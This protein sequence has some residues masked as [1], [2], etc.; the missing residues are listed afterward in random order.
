MTEPDRSAARIGNLK[1][2]GAGAPGFVSGCSAN[3]R[4][5]DPVTQVYPNREEEAGSRLGRGQKSFSV[6]SSEKH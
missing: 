4:V 1:E 5:P 2:A 6:E 3:P